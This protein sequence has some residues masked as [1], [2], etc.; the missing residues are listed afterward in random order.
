[1][2][3]FEL[4]YDHNRAFGYPRRL[5]VVAFAGEFTFWLKLVTDRVLPIGAA[6]KLPIFVLD[7]EA[8][9]KGIG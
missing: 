8:H 2:V 9:T 3:A 1:L 6:R 4:A 5:V 7:G